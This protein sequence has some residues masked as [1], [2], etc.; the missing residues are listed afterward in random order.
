LITITGMVIRTSNLIPEINVGLF[1]CS[2]CH[3]EVAVEVERG[4]IAEPTLCTHCNTNHS[5]ALIHNRSQ[6]SDKQVHL[7]GDRFYKNLK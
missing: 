6:Y 2:V 7:S 1:R 5:F 3:L 4:R